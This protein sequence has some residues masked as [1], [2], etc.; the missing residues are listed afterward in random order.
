MG[1]A[2]ALQGS[3]PV[4]IVRGIESSSTLVVGATWLGG[5]ANTALSSQIPVV[6]EP[7]LGS[8]S[9]GRVQGD[10]VILL[11]GSGL[12][13]IGGF[14]LEEWNTSTRALDPGS[15]ELGVAVAH[16][17]QLIYDLLSEAIDDGSGASSSG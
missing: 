12:Q 8:R 16:G 9:E 3:F 4:I 1:P 10:I 17:F 14:G 13:R 7:L 5:E 6:Q 15:V 11:L 2:I